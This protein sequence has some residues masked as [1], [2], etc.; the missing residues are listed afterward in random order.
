MV[1]HFR[2]F[3]FLILFTVLKNSPIKKINL[4]WQSL[5]VPQGSILGPVLL[6][7]F[8]EDLDAGVECVLSKFTDST[9][10]DVLLTLW[11]DE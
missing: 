6:N 7:I 8:I 3:F 4:L 5:A 10:L 1:Y 2:F 11:R 9:K